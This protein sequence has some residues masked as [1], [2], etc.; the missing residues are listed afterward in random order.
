MFQLQRKPIELLSPQ[1]VK[2]IH[3]ASLDILKNKGIKIFSDKALEIF[4]DHRLNIKPKERVVRF[5]PDIVDEWVRKAPSRFVWH[6][7]NPKKNITLGGDKIAFS[8]ASTVLYVYDLETGFRRK[9]TFEDAQKLVKIIDALNFIDE[10]YCMVYP[11]DIPDSLA[12]VYIVL[13][14]ALYSSKPILGRLNGTAIA[15]DCIKMAE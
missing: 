15:Q 12:H 3:Y 14:N 13:A 4:G 9:A 5:P 11:G 7:R 2:E 1:S 6:A 8:A 10:S